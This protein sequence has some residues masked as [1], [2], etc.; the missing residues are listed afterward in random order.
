MQFWEYRWQPPLFGANL[1]FSSYKTCV[2]GP[3][4][5]TLL[6]PKGCCAGTQGSCGVRC[7]LGEGVCCPLSP[8]MSVSASPCPPARPPSPPRKCFQEYLSL[9]GFT[10][11][12]TSSVLQVANVNAKDGTCTLKD[13]VYKDVQK[14][15]PGYSEGDQKLLKRMLIR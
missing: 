7:W 6:H 10:Q 13:C 8:F 11:G 4:A 3:A 2:S 15:W 5:L 14:D 1:A 12:D 9:L